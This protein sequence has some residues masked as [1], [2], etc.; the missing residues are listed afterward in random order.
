M[1]VDDD[2]VPG[3]GAVEPETTDD[4]ASMR[5]W[6]R[7]RRRRNVA[8]SLASHPPVVPPSSIIFFSM[9]KITSGRVVVFEVDPPLEPPLDELL[10]DELALRRICLDG[11]VNRATSRDTSDVVSHACDLSRNSSNSIVSC[12]S[13]LCNS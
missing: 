2:D 7:D 9:F 10:V 4:E 3:D 13:F 1:E 11:V 8:W 12:L 6:Y 5:R